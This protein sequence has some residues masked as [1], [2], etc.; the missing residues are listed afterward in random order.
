MTYA[1]IVLFCFGDPAAKEEFKEY[2]EEHYP[3]GL[4]QRGE[5]R[6]GDEERDVDGRYVGVGQTRDVPE[7]RHKPIVHVRTSHRRLDSFN[8]VHQVHWL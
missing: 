3:G 4:V 8:K 5:D 7:P 6:Q 1:H 2:A